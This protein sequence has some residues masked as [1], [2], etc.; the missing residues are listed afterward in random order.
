MLQT[1]LLLIVNKA[2]FDCKQGFFLMQTRFVFK[3][4]K[5]LL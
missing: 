4:E 3:R 1:R 2:C 5:L